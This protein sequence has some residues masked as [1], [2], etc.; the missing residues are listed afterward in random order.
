M[1][2]DDKAPRPQPRKGATPP[3]TTGAPVTIAPDGSKTPA[4]PPGQPPVQPAA[5]G[6]PTTQPAQ[7]EGG[8][9]TGRIIT[10]LGELGSTLPVGTIVGDQ[11]IKTL[12]ARNWTTRQE[13]VIA[14]FKKPG[15]NI[16]QHVGLV[17]SCM[18]TDFAN[19][20]WEMPEH[21]KELAE[22]R[23]II[24]QAGMGDVLYA[25]VFL[26]RE[27]MGNV[28][29]INVTCPACAHAWVFPADLNTVDVAMVES[30]EALYWTYDMRRPVQIRGKLVK[31]L[32]MGPPLWHSMES[33]A[34]A[35]ANDA[36]S[37]IA[38]LRG[39]IHGFN[40][41]PQRIQIIEAD[42]DDITKIDLETVV[43]EVDNHFIGPKMA[44]EG[45]CPNCERS[46]LQPIDWRYDSFF[47]ISSR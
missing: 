1:A 44:V 7:Q 27:A 33:A 39:A 12:G 42:L 37:K 38:V 25:Y 14:K 23:A 26:R 36:A 5:P 35:Q 43:K 19:H 13:K 22:R 20:T 34:M 41:D 18:L 4:G 10:T 30:K 9:R 45:Q 8:P 11:L 17:L 6:A 29:N 31:Q 16:A 3:V 24:G 47:S 32:R 2:S 46:F 21:P 40:D 28:I 15:M